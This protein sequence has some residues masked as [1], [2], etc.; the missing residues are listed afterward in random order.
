MT[1]TDRRNV[2]EVAAFIENGFSPSLL[3][4]LGWPQESGLPLQNL[5][6]GKCKDTGQVEG[7]NVKQGFWA[8]TLMILSPE[9]KHNF[10]TNWVCSL[11]M[12]LFVQENFGA[13]DILCSTKM[14]KFNRDSKKLCENLIGSPH[15]STLHCRKE[16]TSGVSLRDDACKASEDVTEWTTRDSSNPPTSYVSWGSGLS[17]M[18]LISADGSTGQ[19]SKWIHQK[20]K[21][22]I[23]G[24]RQPDALQMVQNRL[25][26]HCQ[27][28][29]A[30]TLCPP[31]LSRP[32]T[33]LFELRE[34]LQDG[35]YSSLS[36]FSLSFSNVADFLS[37]FERGIFE[38]P[39]I[40]VCLLGSL[41]GTQYSC[42][43]SEGWD[44]LCLRHMGR[45]RYQVTSCFVKL[46]FLP[47]PFLAKKAWDKTFVSWSTPFLE[48]PYFSLVS[49]LV[50]SGKI[51][52]HLMLH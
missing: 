36:L 41:Y 44:S 52:P 15:H 11:K 50:F 1:L 28:K 2:E 40:G 27:S 12:N 4:S 42:N 46:S 43:E 38:F 47:T 16:V 13:T 31:L 19:L 39:Q 10:E 37:I 34:A 20:A 48:S 3:K 45:P 25:L 35:P 9:P 22:D 29:C 30:H 32:T 8:N 17:C 26:G 5:E 18:M 7:S 33:L 14:I 21:Y 6:G 23:I 49:D 51:N 24:D